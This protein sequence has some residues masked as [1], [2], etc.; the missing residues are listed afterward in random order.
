MKTL[1]ARSNESVMDQVDSV[2]HQ[3]LK[4][5][6]TLE[7]MKKD[8]FVDPMYYQHWTSAVKAPFNER[9]RPPE[10]DLFLNDV[11]AGFLYVQ[12]LLSSMGSDDD[13]RATSANPLKLL[14]SSSSFLT[15]GSIA[16]NVL[17][18]P[19]QTD[20][21]ENEDEDEEDSA[22]DEDGY[23]DEYDEDEEVE[24]TP[25]WPPSH[26]TIPSVKPFSSMSVD[27]QLAV[28]AA[29]VC[30]VLEQF[31]GSSIMSGLEFV[32][33]RVVQLLPGLLEGRPAAQSEEFNTAVWCLTQMMAYLGVQSIDADLT[34]VS[35][36]E[37]GEP[38]RYSMHD[39]NL[40]IGELYAKWR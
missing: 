2:I 28:R 38:V 27:D 15:T 37:H 24:A 16:P 14:N 25:S 8:V 18:F 6:G 36:D 7:G 40:P 19:S 20:E 22:E 29:T 10:I 26:Q 9:V 30:Q 32:P 3:Y 13:A 34:V 31:V 33:T 5:Y 4:K 39:A 21:E 12:R 35:F 1:G 23:E 11:H 17:N